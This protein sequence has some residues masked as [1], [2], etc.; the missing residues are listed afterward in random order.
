MTGQHP[1]SARPHACA[2]SHRS[3]SGWRSGISPAP[4]TAYTGL[5]STTTQGSRARPCGCRCP[6]TQCAIR[7]SI[8]TVDLIWVA[9]P[10]A[11]DLP[12]SPGCP[13]AAGARSTLAPNSREAVPMCWGLPPSHGSH[14]HRGVPPLHEG[15]THPCATPISPAA[16]VTTLRSVLTAS[17]GGR[18]RIVRL[19]LLI[20]KC[21]RAEPLKVKSHRH[22]LVNVD[23]D[24]ALVLPVV[25]PVT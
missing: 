17:V 12:A 14:A 22:G 9:A 2:W 5:S 3:P 8:S 6:C 20:I 24:R 7:G 4:P 10:R 18:V 21:P 19:L 16:F 15:Q 13:A 11:G 25:A 23:H 1:R